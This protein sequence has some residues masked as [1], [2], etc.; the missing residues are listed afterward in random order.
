VN[1][2]NES[3]SIYE[4][5]FV[6]GTVI[7]EVWQLHWSLSPAT[8]Q[9]RFANN[10]RSRKN[11]QETPTDAV[12]LYW[13]SQGNHLKNIKPNIKSLISS[14][15]PHYTFNSPVLD[16]ELSFSPLGGLELL[17]YSAYKS[18]FVS[19]LILPLLLGALDLLPILGNLLPVDP[20]A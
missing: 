7:Q 15:F 8:K 2:K 10:Q 12:S 3:V 9:P 19:P 11:S 20:I 14:H 17:K 1:V 4:Q 16:I 13:V 5:E 6:E 18:P